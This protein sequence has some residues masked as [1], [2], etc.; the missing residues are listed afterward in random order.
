MKIWKNVKQPNLIDAYFTS[1]ETSFLLVIQ[2]NCPFFTL[3][4]NRI[5]V[6]KKSLIWDWSPNNVNREI[7]IFTLFKKTLINT[8]S[9]PIYDLNQQATSNFNPKIHIETKLGNKIGFDDSLFEKLNSEKTALLKFNK[10]NLSNYQFNIQY[11]KSINRNN[12]T[13]NESDR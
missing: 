11:I 10:Q 5:Y 6:S 7:T 1:S 13:Y 9:L 12:L 3:Y 2:S 8:S 4:K